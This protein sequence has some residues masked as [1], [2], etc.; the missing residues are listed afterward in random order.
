MSSSDS[1]DRRV[2][3][4]TMGRIDD[5]AGG[6]SVKGPAGAG[7]DAATEPIE[8]ADLEEIL[9]EAATRG[10]KEKASPAAG[11][12]APARQVEG[13]RARRPSPPPPPKARGSRPSAP[14][15]P[16]P[17]R[18]AR[19]TGPPPPPPGRKKGPTAPPPAPP[20]GALAAAAGAV[21]PTPPAA[22]RP[23]PAPVSGVI[24][25]SEPARAGD[26]ATVL[27]PP[28]A[29]PSG[30]GVHAP[31]GERA[32]R[33]ANTTGAALRLPPTL[34]RRSGVLGDMLYVYTAAFGVAGSR[35]ELAAVDRKLAAEKE[36]RD[37]RLIEVARAALVDG[38]LQSA[39]LDRGRD[40]LLE[41]EEKRSRRAGAIAA[42]EE[43]IAALERDREE[44]RARHQRELDALR[45][46]IA[47]L[48]EKLEPLER[49]AQATRKR[50]QKLKD[51][52]A[53][54][55]R[56]IARGEA[57]LAGAESAE[58]AEIEASLAS[59]K[60]DRESVAEEEPVI[61]A[62][63]D[64][65]E[66]AIA[67]LGAN[68]AEA[69]ARVERLE[70]A[71]AAAQVRGAEMITAVR[72]RSAVE[73]RAEAELAREQE[74]ALRALG[75]RLEVERPEGLVP[76]LRAVEEHE[77]A[78][79]T[80]ER[81]RVELGELVRGIDRWALTRGVLWLILLAAAIAAGVLWVLSQR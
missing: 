77:V 33:V 22:R 42:A 3:D 28:G 39:V 40:E 20:P 2:G 74:E 31:P 5:L 62:E 37:R 75:E 44:E 4:A 52:L 21:P 29:T 30:S 34:P 36:A 67:S 56:R 24:E 63:L 64:D 79:A 9:A 46:E 1:R 6:W 69:R 78:I 81:R 54:L 32:R 59:M 70:K 72:A 55:D 23:D 14:P 60:A 57:S 66:P 12:G 48:D 27:S 51:A 71:E 35:R 18:K 11:P 49:E 80:L 26:D 15:P 7:K 41:I 47:E 50:A 38:E 19:S 45:R 16:P 61:A 43:E 17:G 73:E 68:L 8:R 58:R 65:L 10:E 53:E 13:S 76:R 25:A